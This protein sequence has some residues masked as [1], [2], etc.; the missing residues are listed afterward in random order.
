M[1][2]LKTTVE[3]V[4]DGAFSGYAV[5]ESVEALLE[6]T[7]QKL[8]F[9]DR[10]IPSL[11]GFPP[12][13]D[14]TE[15]PLY[16]LGALILQDK[17]SCFPAHLLDPPANA[18]VV[19]GTAAP[20]NKTTHLAALLGQK[21]K[22]RIF[23]FEKDKRRGEVLK[24]MVAKA[25]GNDIIEVRA[26]ED[27][28]K[29]DPHKDPGLSIATH[30]L[31][32]PSCSGSGIVMRDEYE[33]LPPPSKTAPMS[34]SGPGKGKKRKRV[35]VASAQ[36][37]L[38]PAQ[39]EEKKDMDKQRLAS[40]AE[41]QKNIVQFAMS[42]PAARKITYS[43]CSI[44]TEENED[45]V[46][47]V[48]ES[49]VAKR[50]G[51]R[52]LRR[53]E[54]P[55]KDWFRRG[56]RSRCRSDEIAAACIRCNPVEDGGIGFFVVGFIRDGSVDG[57]IVDDR[58]EKGLEDGNGENTFGDEEWVGFTDE[59]VAPVPLPIQK[60]QDGARKIKRKKKKAKNMATLGSR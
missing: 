29:V 15:H 49:R 21:T 32:D 17:A 23:A 58:D 16:I 30:V 39:E 31:L 19:D 28:L 2:T 57:Y 51:W 13:T 54:G 56:D 46:T 53:E 38:G 60:I 43:T 59:E 52:V 10:D 14:L 9:R 35:T 41:F 50:R 27:L 5:V 42:F 18:Y 33:L 36:P 7:E 3:T 4:L 22:G 12:S 6:E 37:A 48:L 34:R 20:G 11:L 44:H 25:G 40:L 45:V 26:G 1:N 47:A 24:S 55:L 8:V